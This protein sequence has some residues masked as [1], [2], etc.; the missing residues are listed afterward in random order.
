[1]NLSGKISLLL[2]LAIALALPAR[3][4]MFGSGGAQ[5]P[6]RAAT[7]LPPALQ[8]VDFRP[9]LDAA[10]PL[11]LVFRDES[12]RAVKLGDYFQ[13]GKPVLLAMVYYECPMLCT[14]VEQGVSSALK[15]VTLNPGRDFQ[16]VFVSF[17]PK[18]KPELAAQKKDF[19]VNYY[20]REGTAEG[21][22][23]LTGDEPSIKALAESVGFH[24]ALDPDT[25][26]YAH[27]SGILLITP[28][29]RISR[30]F[31]GIEYPPRDLRLGLVEASAGEI[32]TPIDHLLLF[33]YQYDP[34]TG[35]YS[36]SILGAVRAGGILTLLGLGIFVI[37]HLRRD[38]RVLHRARNG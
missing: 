8:Q 2:T 10:V 33:C 27:A 31:Y 9:Q 34:R 36:A 20:H 5:P 18:E 17:N 16:V 11:G 30:Y 4:Q 25:G 32:G 22:H 12:G 29:G 14:Q 6:G 15:V 21:F 35:R 3:A 38:V 7:G 23:F 24:Y 26:L 19:A 28:Q 37:V 13:P 1:M